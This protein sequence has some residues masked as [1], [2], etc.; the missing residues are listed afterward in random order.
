LKIGKIDELKAKIVNILNIKFYMKNQFVFPILVAFI[1]V[2]SLF[3]SI[4]INT[5]PVSGF[6]IDETGHPEITQRALRDVQAKIGG[7]SYKFTPKSIEEIIKAN[8]DVDHD[9]WGGT[10][11]GTDS[12]HFDDELLELGFRRVIAKKKGT[13]NQAKNRIGKEARKELGEALH[14]LQ[15]F[16]AH[17]NYVELVA[18]GVA[19]NIVWD[20]ILPNSVFRNPDPGKQF[21]SRDDPSLLVEYGKK[22]LT[23]GYFPFKKDLAGKCAHGGAYLDPLTS[24]IAKDSDSHAGY[25]AAFEAAKTATTDFVNIIIKNILDDNT[26]KD[27]TAVIKSLMGITGGSV[28]F[29]VDTTGSMRTEIDTVK[30]QM[31]EFIAAVKKDPD[32]QPENYILVLFGDPYVAP[33]R[34]TTD[35]DEFINWISAIIVEGGD[36]CPEYSM[37]G[38]RTAVEAS[39]EGSNIFLFTDADA[40]DAFLSSAVYAEAKKKNIIISNALTGSCSS[41]SK[42]SRSN[43]ADETSKLTNI[44]FDLVSHDSNIED[45]DPVYEEI[46]RETGGLTYRL[47]KSELGKIFKI[48]E[49]SSNRSFD[50]ILLN[51]VSVTTTPQSFIFDVDSTITK[52][53]ISVAGSNSIKISVTNPS[54]AVIDILSTPAVSIYTHSGGKLYVI[55]QPAKGQWKVSTSGNGQAVIRVTSASEL[56]FSD[57]NFLEPVKLRHDSFRSLGSLPVISKTFMVEAKLIGDV[58]SV[59]FKAI[60]EN[61]EVL[62]PNLNLAPAKLA[63]VYQGSMTIPAQP[64]RIVAQGVDSSGAAFKRVFSSLF[65]GQLI[66]LTIDWDK[67]ISELAK[68][69]AGSSPDFSLYVT[70]KN[71]GVPDS[72]TVSSSAFCTKV[73]SVQPSLIT[74]TTN[75]SQTILV[76]ISYPIT[77]E[78]VTVPWSLTARGK[79]NSTQVATITDRFSLPGN[80]TPASVTLERFTAQRTSTATRIHW[81]TAIEQDSWSFTVFRAEGVY[82]GDKIPDLAQQVNTEVILAKGRGGGGASYLLEDFTA[83][84]NISYTYW[85]MESEAN[86]NT[87]IYG[88]AI[89][90]NGIN[91]SYL[92]FLRGTYQ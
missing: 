84:S 4:A 87:K 24:G 72:F 15:D 71:Y 30:E 11:K 18:S 78:I 54:G 1:L 81:V 86:G 88:P 89:W 61:G 50:T 45:Y 42:V 31:I 73:Q 74:L 33:A 59:S 6:D 44:A 28:T 2:I 79:S 64:F 83:Y 23:T 91:K 46:S 41:L 65:I 90:I 36:D 20:D 14:T 37:T 85:L 9:T 57:F 29:V 70:I 60:G 35:P 52:L 38:L 43:Y 58:K 8:K 76:K 67:T 32:I 40:K 10:R 22:E 63:G 39:A 16:Y 82:T 25:T 56:L 3:D 66:G 13:I 68:L 5:R 34:E 53:A 48:L 77:S 80:L 55:A 27:K 17:S 69:S 26:I 51:S 47:A 75:M 21:C 12:F 62:I 7:N 92:P 49:I 19:P